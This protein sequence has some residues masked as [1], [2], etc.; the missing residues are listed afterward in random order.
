MVS[1]P[2]GKSSVFGIAARLRAGRF[3]VQ[4]T[5]EAKDLSFMRYVSNRSG[6][7]SVS[8]SVVIE[9]LL[10]GVKQP[11]REVNN[12]YP[13]S[14]RIENGKGKVRPRT[15]HEGPELEKRYGFTLSLTSA[16]DGGWLVSATPLWVSLRE[17][18]PVPIVQ[19]AG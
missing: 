11:G 6:A 19:E 3:G 15:G 4:F 14:V 5:A 1:V 16:I 8:Y 18:N 9:V 10:P 2:C 7:C 12:S 13:S 17:R